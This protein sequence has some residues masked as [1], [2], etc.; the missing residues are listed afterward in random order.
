MFHVNAG[1]NVSLGLV[2]S[3]L[4]TEPLKI[5]FADS[6]NY[7]SL[8]SRITF[9]SN[10]TEISSL[11]GKK[12]INATISTDSRLAPGTYVLLVTVSDGFNNQ[13]V[14]VWLQVAN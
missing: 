6:E 1:S 7:T 10:E 5:Q 4:S 9:R 14:Y 11:N 2:A 12:V 3:G 8:P 13:G